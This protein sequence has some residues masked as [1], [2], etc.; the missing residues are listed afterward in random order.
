MI[1]M[2][3]TYWGMK[4]NPFD[5]SINLKNTF[6]LDDFLQIQSRLEYLVDKRGIGVFTGAAGLR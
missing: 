5:K 4:C 1:T 3:S 6:K 2:Y